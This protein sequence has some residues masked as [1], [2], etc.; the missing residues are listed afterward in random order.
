MVQKMSRI[1]LPIVCTI[2]VFAIQQPTQAQNSP[3]TVAARVGELLTEE[4]LTGRTTAMAASRVDDETF[5]RRIYL[6]IVGELPTVDDI[7]SFTLDTSKYKREKAINTLL[8]DEAYG[9]NWARYWRDVIL[10]RK[11]EERALIAAQPL[12]EYLTNRFN[13]N[14]SWD[15]IATSFI[16]A[17]GDVRENGEC[18]LIVAQ[19]G[20]PEETVAEISRIF[21]GIQI[22]CA[23]CHNHPTDRWTREQFH[24][25][26]AFFPRVASRQSRDQDYRTFYVVAQDSFF[27]R[28]QGNNNN[29]FIGTPEHHM[30][31][32]DHPEEQGKQMQPVFFVTGE[33]LKVGATDEDRR[34]TLADWVS[35]PQN[36]WFAHALVNRL[37]SEL[38]GEGFYEPVDDM[39]PDR[40]CT[41]PKTLEY[42]AEECID[43]EYDIKWLFRTIMATDAYQRES[44]SRRN[45]DETPFLANC[46][47]RLRADQL[48]SSLVAALGLPDRTLAAGRQGY[49]VAR[50]PRLAINL[51]FGFDPS[52]MRD[53]VAG[54]IPQSLFLMNSFAINQAINSRSN[55]SLGRLMSEIQNDNDLVTE[56]YLKVLAREPTKEEMQTCMSYVRNIGQRNEAFEDLLWALVNSTEFLHRR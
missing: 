50:G 16:T 30:P 9:K 46:N 21:M 25:L 39:G 8:A 36:P 33:K 49:G 26:A 6:D 45:Y 38:V 51:Q 35:A 31:D 54:S 18:A 28:R 17:E 14:M 3:R 53:E 29:R 23:Q 5:I 12:E 32:L 24:E 27:R 52:E 1:V 19:G 10:Y 4:V 11:T 43:N 34:N 7:L 56:L 22:Q 48:Y 13:K 44:R 55:S 41:A 15:D 47:Q 42:L 20:K 40:E 2:V 37:W